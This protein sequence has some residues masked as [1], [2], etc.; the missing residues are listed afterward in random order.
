MAS[1]VIVDAEIWIWTSTGMRR[2]PSNEGFIATRE[3]ERLLEE[4]HERGRQQGLRQADE[5]TKR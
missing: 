2:T 3:I 1:A 4:A 5:E